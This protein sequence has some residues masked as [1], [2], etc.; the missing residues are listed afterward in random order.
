VELQDL[1]R[2][3]SESSPKYH[4]LPDPSWAYRPVV[5]STRVPLL[6]ATSW[7]TTHGTPTTVRL[8]RVTVISTCSAAPSSVPSYTGSYRALGDSAGGG[9]GRG[10][11]APRVYRAAVSTPASSA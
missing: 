1:G 2:E 9:A 6:V 4:T 3:S 7:T 10:G 11:R 5:S 8:D